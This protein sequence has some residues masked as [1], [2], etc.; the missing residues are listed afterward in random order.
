ME[1]NEKSG[2]YFSMDW[3]ETNGP[4]VMGIYNHKHF[5]YMTGTAARVFIVVFMSVFFLAF[6]TI[7]SW[8]F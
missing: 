8:V 4:L 6:L 3:N 1:T 5:L 2:L 7:L